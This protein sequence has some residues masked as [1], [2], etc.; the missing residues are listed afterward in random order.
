MKIKIL[1]I[2]NSLICICLAIIGFTSSCNGPDE[3]GTPYAKF[4]IKG[5][6]SSEETG[7]VI[8]GIQALVPSRDSIYTD[9][10][11]NFRLIIE[12][13]PSDSTTFKMEFNDID[14]E[15]DGLFQ[16]ADTS[17]TF[18][19][20]KFS[21]GDDDWYKGETSKEINIKLTRKNAGK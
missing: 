20:P 6:V 5:K 14:S 12:D 4:I 10:E 1:K 9:D 13:F 8:K 17:I 7:Q 21:G 3:Y 2:Y 16:N 18:L 15:Q 11:G 19:N